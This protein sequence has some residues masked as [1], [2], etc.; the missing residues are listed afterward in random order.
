MQFPAKC[1]TS[2]LTENLRKKKPS[3]DR[4]EDVTYH[5]ATCIEFGRNH[6]NMTDLFPKYHSLYISIN[7]TFLYDKHRPFIHCMHVFN[8][9]KHDFHL[10]NME[11]RHDVMRWQIQWSLSS[12]ISLRVVLYIS[13]GRNCCFHLQDRAVN[14]ARIRYYFYSLFSEPWLF[15][16]HPALSLNGPT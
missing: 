9:L 1:L 8:P 7:T 14:R 4:L 3:C 10:N 12:G 16:I 5:N 15:S 2:L 13:F 11:F 6:T